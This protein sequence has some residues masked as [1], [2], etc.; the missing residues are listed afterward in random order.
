MTEERKKN[1]ESSLTVG[2]VLLIF[3]ILTVAYS[4]ADKQVILYCEAGVTVPPRDNFKN[5]NQISYRSV[6]VMPTLPFWLCPHTTFIALLHSIGIS[7]SVT[8]CMEKI[9]HRGVKWPTSHIA[10]RGAAQVLTLFQHGHI[11]SLSSTVCTIII[12]PWKW[13][14]INNLKIEQNFMITSI[15]HMRKN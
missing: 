14:E 8:L 5:I 13:N 15:Y 2:A 12:P 6:L 3:S 11:L 10:P 4:I 7:V 1:Q 9:K